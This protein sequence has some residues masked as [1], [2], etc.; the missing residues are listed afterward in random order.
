MSLFQEFDTLRDSVN[1]ML[2]DFGTGLGSRRGGR[3][4]SGWND[5]FLGPFS[6]WDEDFFDMPLMLPSGDIGGQ[7]LL[8]TG[9][10]T[11]DTKMDDVKESGQSQALTQGQGTQMA[12]FQPQQFMRARVNIED[13]KDKYIVTAE[14]PGFDKSNV[15]VNVTDDGLLHIKGEQ[16]KEWVD[17]SKEKKYVRAERTFSNVQRSLRLPRGVDASR[18]AASY[19]N[20]ILHIDLPKSEEKKPAEV[21]IK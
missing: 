18:I 3:R 11:D 20:G 5:P 17:Q 15:K 10:G 9:K 4:R 16:T 1:R 2:G 8:T 12:T 19:E 21:Q 14:M 7:S 6:G 13:A